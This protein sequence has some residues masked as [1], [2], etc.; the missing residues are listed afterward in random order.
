MLQLVVL[1]TIVLA[2]TA[3]LFAWLQERDPTQ[4]EVELPQPGLEAV[5]NLHSPPN[6]PGGFNPS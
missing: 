5:F 6:P 4:T 2:F 3:A 1:I